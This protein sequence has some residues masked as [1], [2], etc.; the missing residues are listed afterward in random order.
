M[1]LWVSGIVKSQNGASN[2]C[3]AHCDLVGEVRTL[4]KLELCSKSYP[5]YCTQ[6][7]DHIDA[8]SVAMVNE[9][10]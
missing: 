6:R 5:L 3:A 2:S 9:C 10:S 4:K 7:Q 1:F 8:S